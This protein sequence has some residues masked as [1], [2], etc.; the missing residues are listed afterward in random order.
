MD[1]AGPNA[2]QRFVDY[3]AKQSLSQQTLERFEAVKERTLAV[4]RRFG[5][6]T[7]NLA[8]AD[9]GCGPGAQ[10]LLWA[11][12]GHRVSGLDISVPLV[13]LARSRAAEAGLKAEFTV[14]T[15]TDLPFDSEAFDVVLVPELLEHLPQWEPCLRE[16]VRVLRPGGVIYLCT[17][18]RLCPVQQEFNLP[19]Y[20]WYPA[21]LK[22]RCEK[23]AV[24]THGEW[25][26]YT[27]FPAVNWFSFYQLRD[28]LAKF[29][30]TSLDRFDVL[31]TS[32]SAKRAAVVNAMRLVSPLRFVGQVLTP[33]T[34][35]YGFKQPAS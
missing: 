15:A 12:E 3:Y 8:V 34:A 19:L 33:H 21:W 10:S 30:I 9:I 32:G 22:R 18:N 7:R 5:R 4:L 16:V 31:D 11:S 28:E 13:E 27:S 1:G 17:T 25:V 35:V 23:L 20:S 26:Q 2:D 6:S 14:G 29:R 24:T